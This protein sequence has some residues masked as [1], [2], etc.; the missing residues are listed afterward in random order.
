MNEVTKINRSIENL[1]LKSID[2]SVLT[3]KKLI[4]RIQK[5]DSEQKAHLNDVFVSFECLNHEGKSEG[6]L[7]SIEAEFST[8]L[9]EGMIKSLS[10]IAG[11]DCSVLS[12]EAEIY[13]IK[14]FDTAFKFYDE[15]VQRLQKIQET[16]FE[17]LMT[18]S[19][20]SRTFFA[21]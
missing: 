12:G 1:I 11:T 15:S 7:V 4:I 17:Q 6:F 14:N 19:D 20:E 13:F 10:E 9:T 3:I 21:A 2:R 8:D 16:A 5:E 18:D